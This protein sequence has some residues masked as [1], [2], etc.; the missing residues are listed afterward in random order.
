MA[1]RKRSGKKTFLT[2]LLVFLLLIGGGAAVVFSLFRFQKDEPSNI[3]SDF[4]DV[5]PDEDI[6]DG[7]GNVK[8]SLDILSEV[9]G[10]NDL[11]SIL[12][13]WALNNTDNSLM[14]DNDV[15]NILLLGID[16]GGTNSDVIMLVSINQKTKKIFL[17]SIM[18]DSY[19]YI[20]TGR[21]EGYGKI[22]S[23]YANGGSPCVVST[24]QNDFKVRIDYY[25]TVN[26]NT[27]K[28]IVDQ[29]GGVEV[30]VMEYE[31][32][33][34][35]NL[36][37]YGDSVLLNGDQALM[38]CRIRYCDADGDVSRTRRQRQFIT[39]LIDRCRDLDVSQ[40]ADVVSTLLK[41]VK[42]DCPTSKILS[43]ATKAVTG[44]WYN[45]DVIPITLPTPDFRMDYMGYAWVWIVDYPPLAQYLQDTV[46]EETNIKLTRDRVSAIDVMRSR[47]TGEAR[48]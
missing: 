13:D 27:F 25:V 33:A 5:D 40:A 14:Y 39:A 17:S 2:V 43:Y 23:A 45:Y 35:E 11:S 21:S 10:D 3:P 41:Y 15:I 22:N 48:P 12:K 44:K 20:T 8:K 7:S 37:T 19:T 36:F 26:F 30:P 47:S 29:I 18:R 1:K 6:S 24:V 16:E 34:M 46:Y 38:Y 31:M 28:A 9:K 42:T 4:V 32:I